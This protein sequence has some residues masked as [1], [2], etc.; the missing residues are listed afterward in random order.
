MHTGWYP[1]AEYIL[2]IRL[3]VPCFLTWTSR[4]LGKLISPKI[5]KEN[6]AK[7]FKKDSVAHVRYLLLL[8]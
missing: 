8:S 5:G 2:S 6:Y 7:I 4:P 3:T 1:H